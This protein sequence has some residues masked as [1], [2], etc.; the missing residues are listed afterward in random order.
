M[1]KRPPGGPGASRWARP[2]PPSPPSPAPLRW[3]SVPRL[4]GVGQARGSAGAG[5]GTRGVR[6]LLGAGGRCAPRHGAVPGY[7]KNV[8]ALTGFCFSVKG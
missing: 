2:S 1:G 8:R 7:A 3:R 4:G 5:T 6:Q